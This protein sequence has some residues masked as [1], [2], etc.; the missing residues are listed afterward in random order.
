[1]I[2]LKTTTSELCYRYFGKRIESKSTHHSYLKGVLLSH[3][4]V[5]ITFSAEQ[6][7]ADLAFEFWGGFRVL[8]HDVHLQ[9]QRFIVRFES[10]TTSPLAL[11]SEIKP[12]W[13]MTKDFKITYSISPKVTIRIFS[14]VF[15]SVTAQI[16]YKG[17]FT[18]AIFFLGFPLKSDWTQSF[19]NMLLRAIIK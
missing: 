3:V 2:L 6:R 17:A 9:N 18:P 11:I 1:M 14:E 19:N 8:L 4:D 10:H 15:L 16:Q 5:Q 13:F 7:Q 12:D